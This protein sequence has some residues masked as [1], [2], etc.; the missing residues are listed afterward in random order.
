MR[1]AGYRVIIRNSK[2]EILHIIVGNLGLNTNNVIEVWGLLCGLQATTKQEIFPIIAKSESDIFINL[3][4]NLLNGDDP[5]TYEWNSQNLIHP[6]ARVGNPPF[7]CT[8]NEKSSCRPAGK[9]RI[10]ARGGSLHVLAHL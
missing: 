8:M 1:P 5:E 7:P 9:C 2:G 6:P 3:F 10:R 4:S